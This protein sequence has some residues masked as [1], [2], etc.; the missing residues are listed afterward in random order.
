M[1][2]INRRMAHFLSIVPKERLMERSCLLMYCKQKRE[3]T[4]TF[5]KKTHLGINARV[6]YAEKNKEIKVLF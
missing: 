5:T 6:W 4:S 1:P 2:V 3:L